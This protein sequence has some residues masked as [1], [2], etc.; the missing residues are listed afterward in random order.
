MDPEEL[1]KLLGESLN[2]QLDGVRTELTTE[3]REWMS[4]ESAERFTA[5]EASL[6][7]IRSELQKK[8]IDDPEDPK[9]T[10]VTELEKRLAEAE[11]SQTEMAETLRL[12]QA[13]QTTGDQAVE[14]VDYGGV[15]LKKTDDLK[16]YLRSHWNLSHVDEAHFRTLGSGLFATGGQL[17]A[18]AADAFIDF[19]IAQ[20]MTLPK[21]VT[22]RM[23]APTGYTD[24]LRVS[25]RKMIAATEA[26]APAVADAVTTKR[27]TLTSVE[28][29]WAED[30]TLTLLEDAIER[31][32]TEGHIARLIATGFGND[33][34]DLAWNGDDSSSDP[35]VGINDGW[36]VLLQNSA[37]SDI[38]D[39]DFSASPEPS[40]VTELLADMLQNMSSQFL[41]RTDHRYWCSIGLAQKYAEEVSTRETG[42]GDQVLINGLP[43]LRYFGIPLNP[44]TH[45]ASASQ[46]IILTPSSNLFFGIQRV[47]RVDSEW[48]PRKRIVEY[49]M[50]ARTD[51]EYATGQAVV[52]GHDVPTALN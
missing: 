30:I 9:R 17:P 10:E 24:E 13:K 6:A 45:I 39:V 2:T 5:F 8:F 7:E 27:R 47:M 15:F 41:G 48:V 44:D 35:F 28:V 20:Q 37:D 52:N 3:L 43:S 11:S 25:S 23:A 38:T 1:K 34:N 46:R 16:R 31:A 49:T 40:S 12:I 19:V 32:G 51:Y 50:S 42:L 18:T 4:G 33:S 14:K 29:I 22:I 21:V 36:L 26:T